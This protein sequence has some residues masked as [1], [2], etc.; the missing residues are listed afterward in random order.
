MSEINSYAVVRRRSRLTNASVLT[1]C[2]LQCACGPRPQGCE[3]GDRDC[4]VTTFSNLST[5]ACVC[6]TDGIPENLGGD[7]KRAAAAHGKS[8]D[9]R[10]WYTYHWNCIVII[11]VV[12]LARGSTEAT[13]KCR[14]IRFDDNT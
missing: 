10:R 2:T 12:L 3:K 4:G 11:V 8:C 5:T 13:G 14:L 9:R 1:P 7:A 6:I